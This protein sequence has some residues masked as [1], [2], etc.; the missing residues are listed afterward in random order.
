MVT[1][2]RIS[3]GLTSNAFMV[4]LRLESP[5]YSGGAE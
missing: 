4:L 3:E 1:I 2:P 5:L